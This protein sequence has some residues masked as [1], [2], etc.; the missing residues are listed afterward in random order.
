MGHARFLRESGQ[1][2]NLNVNPEALVRPELDTGVPHGDLLLAFADAIIGT[3]RAALDGARSM[4][5]EALGPVAV[6]GAAAMAANFS[7]NDRIAN[8]MGIPV[9]AIVLKGTEELRAQLGIDSYRSAI[10]T[11]RHPELR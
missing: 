11:F 2:T 1:A 8:G 5:A 4:L 3:D 10:N 9:D 6:A 7:K